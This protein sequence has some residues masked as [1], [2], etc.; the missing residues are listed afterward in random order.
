[1]EASKIKRRG[2]IVSVAL[3][4]I[5]ALLIAVEF[6]LKT[7]TV[8]DYVFYVFCIPGLLFGFPVAMLFG[9]GGPHGEGV[10]F[11]ILIGLP[12]NVFAYYWLTI[13]I[14]KRFFPDKVKAK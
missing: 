8:L 1:M 5:F 3:H 13:Q 6:S 11:G 2:L 7:S 14:I 4:L 10:F 12:F 9:V